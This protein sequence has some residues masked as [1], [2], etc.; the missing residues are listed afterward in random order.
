MRKYLILVCTILSVGLGSTAAFA[1]CTSSQQP[2]GSTW[3]TCVD[4]NGRMYCESCPA[5]GGVCQVVSCN[6]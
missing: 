6:S 1:S 4:D 2:D 3:K 5:G